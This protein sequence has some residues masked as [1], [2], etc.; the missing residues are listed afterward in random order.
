MVKIDR[1][2]KHYLSCGLIDIIEKRRLGIIILT[3]MYMGN[4]KNFY[5]SQEGEFMKVTVEELF[6]RANV[7]WKLMYE[8]EAVDISDKDIFNNN[9]SE[10]EYGRFCHW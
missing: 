5:K 1:L 10:I 6:N 3:L 7:D 9:T 8:N 2:F 4:P